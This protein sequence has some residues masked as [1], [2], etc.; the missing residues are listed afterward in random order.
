MEATLV[1]TRDNRHKHLR[2]S[3][4]MINTKANVAHVIEV[5]LDNTRYESP[6]NQ[7]NI[8]VTTI[9]DDNNGTIKWEPIYT[10]KSD[11][12]HVINELIAIKILTTGIIPKL[13]SRDQAMFTRSMKCINNTRQEENVPLIHECL[14]TKNKLNKI[15]PVCTILQPGIDT[16]SNWE[17]ELEKNKLRLEIMVPEKEAIY[18][19]NRCNSRVKTTPHQCLIFRETLL[20]VNEQ[21]ELMGAHQLQLNHI[22][23]LALLISP[24]MVVAY[25]PRLQ[26]HDSESTD[27][28][29]VAEKLRLR[30]QS[31]GG[32]STDYV[33]TYSEDERTTYKT[34]TQ[35]HEMITTEIPNFPMIDR[36]NVEISNN[37]N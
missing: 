4:E 22:C 17:D 26:S 16:D 29:A 6:Q 24:D 15:I 3:E 13:T 20:R 23:D 34:I 37:N 18:S 25:K 2:T 14:V 8:E 31:S 21:R 7:A 33:D 10:G 32:S 19:I 12:G 11:N 28:I 30:F 9:V 35:D 1:H 5:A 27:D 36:T